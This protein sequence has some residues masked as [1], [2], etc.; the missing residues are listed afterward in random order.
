M[1]NELSIAAGLA[2]GWQLRALE[3]S[4]QP[5]STSLRLAE[6]WQSQWHPARL[7]DNFFVFVPSCSS[8]L[9]TARR[10]FQRLRSRL[11]KLLRRTKAG[12]KYMRQRMLRGA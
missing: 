9:N 2:H 1:L 10:H 12:H 11:K 6:H 8:W 4:I 5:V 7:L 3:D